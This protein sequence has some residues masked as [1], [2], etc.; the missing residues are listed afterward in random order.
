[1]T[2][3][4]RILS[5]VLCAA[6]FVASCLLVAKPIFHLAE[7]SYV[8]SVAVGAPPD[9]FFPV[10]VVWPAAEGWQARVLLY[11][12]LDEFR[13][14]HTGERLR[15]PEG[16]EGE[17]HASLSAWL[18]SDP[19]APAVADFEILGDKDGRQSLRVEC[20]W[21]EKQVNVGWYYATDD[22]LIP[23]R[24]LFYYFPGLLMAVLPLA[25]LI[26]LGLWVAGYLALVRLTGGRAAEIV[27]LEVGGEPPTPPGEP[28][29][30][31]SLRRSDVP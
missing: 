6:L 13:L 28:H 3:L 23:D 1:M 19:G 5:M 29:G 30:L 15:V 2:F 24:H 26:T 10:L 14:M 4:L 25:F 7:R 22:L 8:R 18:A 20:Q 31:D 12:H 16:R 21:D 11:P 27:H 17:V 9:P